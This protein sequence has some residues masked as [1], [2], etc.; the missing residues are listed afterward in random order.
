MS[1]V[2]PYGD[3]LPE[4]AAVG[5]G[6]GLISN[7]GNVSFNVTQD[8]NLQLIGS[9]GQTLWSFDDQDV[10]FVKMQGDGNCVGYTA[11]GTPVWATESNGTDNPY[12]LVCQNDGN[13]VV[14]ANG[15]VPVWATDTGGLA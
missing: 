2:H 3:T 12:A 6:Y 10:S 7:N 1:F 8:G 4:G 9:S 15:G 11:D 13:L 14:Y 5:R